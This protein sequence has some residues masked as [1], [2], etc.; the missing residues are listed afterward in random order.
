MQHTLSE[1]LSL[2]DMCLLAVMQP[3]H[4]NDTAEAAAA[5]AP[6]TNAPQV[7]VAHALVPL[8]AAAAAAS[9]GPSPTTSTCLASFHAHVTASGLRAVRSAQYSAASLYYLADA[10][11]NFE[12]RI[13]TGCFILQAVALVQ[14]FRLF[15][16][17]DPLQHEKDA[18]NFGQF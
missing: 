18:N 10:A 11:F 2:R 6:T 16:N 15:S 17:Q 12:E 5:D 8:A 4:S 3:A 7:P 9:A 14:C 1:S 13:A